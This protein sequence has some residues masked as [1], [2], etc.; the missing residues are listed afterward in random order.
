MGNPKT[1]TLLREVETW[2]GCR[3]GAEEG[4]KGWRRGADTPNSAIAGT[5]G[6][7]EGEMGRCGD[8]RYL[9]LG[10]LHSAAQAVVSQ[11]L[12]RRSRRCPRS[13]SSRHSRR[14]HYRGVSTRFRPLS[15]KPSNYL[16]A[17]DLE[18]HFRQE[19]HM[20]KAQSCSKANG[21]SNVAATECARSTL[22]SDGVRNHRGAS[23]EELD[24]SLALLWRRQG[25]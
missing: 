13:V 11:T 20:F 7:G 6:A 15:G 19:P 23:L 17:I 10:L 1:Q 16:F 14:A 21:P 2:P 25:Q 12:S 22:V 9:H 8:A 3:R 4:G 24:T 18:E 5:R